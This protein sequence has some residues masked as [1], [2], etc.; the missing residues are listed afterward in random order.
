MTKV[1]HL[2]GT[3]FNSDFICEIF[4]FRL[5]DNIQLSTNSK[6]TKRMV[7]LKKDVVSSLEA[8]KL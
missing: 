5:D 7:F 3:H 2:R 8:E 6:S 4:K 1:H